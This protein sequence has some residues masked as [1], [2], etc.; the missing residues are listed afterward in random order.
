[1]SVDSFNMLAT[2][3]TTGDQVTPF[4]ME[5]FRANMWF[6][7]VAPHVSIDTNAQIP[8]DLPACIQNSEPQSIFRSNGEYSAVIMRLA[9]EDKTIVVFHR[10]KFQTVDEAL[11]F[12]A[13]AVLSFW[14]ENFE[15]LCTKCVES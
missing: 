13:R 7:F 8:Y 12:R 15:E 6:T 3:D 9:L 2:E 10:R 1:M 11:W 14:S 5:K 4:C